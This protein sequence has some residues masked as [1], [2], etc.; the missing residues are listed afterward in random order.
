MLVPP[1]EGLV[2]GGPQVENV[3]T[4]SQV[5]LKAER[6]QNNTVPDWERQPQLLVGVT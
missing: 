2:D 3:V 6:F 4:H 5:V 1:H